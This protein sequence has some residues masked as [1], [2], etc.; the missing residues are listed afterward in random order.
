[1]RSRTCAACMSP[2]APRRSASATAARRPSTSAAQL[3]V[4][5]IMEGSVR[6][7][8]DRVRVT[9]QLVDA[10]NGYHLWSENFDRNARRHLRDPGRNRAQ[11]RQRR[12][13][14]PEDA[15]RLRPA[16]ATRRATCAPTSS[17]CAAA[18]SS[19]ARP[20]SREA[21]AADVPPRDRAR[22]GLRAGVRGPGRF[23][24]RV[25]AVAHGDRDSG[26]LEEAKAAAH[27][28]LELDPDLAEAHV[29]KGHALMIAGDHDGATEAFEHALKLDPEL[30]V[31]H[32]LLRAPLLHAG[33][34]RARRGPVRS[35]APR[36]TR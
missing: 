29:A 33:Q 11:R 30:Y 32:Y 7:A 2:R 6:K 22:S 12:A 28:A 15:A 3:H 34:L 14:V 8:G 17:T 26:A 24:V 21:G 23:A 20:K 35:R 31:A 25:D 4:A 5:A 36:A 18:S 13:A 27:R 16:E 1:M 19:A 9:A 10:S